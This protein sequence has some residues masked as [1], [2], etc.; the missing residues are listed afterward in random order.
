GLDRAFADALRGIGDDEVRIHLRPRA[1]PVAL[2][3]HAERVVEREAVGG[4]LREANPVDRTGEV[5]A[6]DGE[7]LARV[8]K[9]GDRLEDALAL[10]EGRFHRVDEPPVGFAALDDQSVDHHGDVVL[11]LL[12][13]VDVLVERADGPVDAGAGEAALARIL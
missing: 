5:L 11:A 4:E 6:V 1:E 13:E 3:A 12:I 8:W 9:L 2:L 10:A 7:G